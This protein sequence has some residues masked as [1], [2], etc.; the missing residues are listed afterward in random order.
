MKGLA[1]K[2]LQYLTDSGGEDN[3]LLETPQAKLTRPLLIESAYLG[4][5][6]FL[7]ANEAQ[8]IEQAGDV[9][10][11]P[12]EVR[13]LLAKGMDEEGLRKIHAVKKI[14]HGARIQ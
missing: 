13:S 7:V 8:E 2:A 4:E 11:L 5:R 9:C 10:Y 1:L 3:D 12:E 6:L 14:F